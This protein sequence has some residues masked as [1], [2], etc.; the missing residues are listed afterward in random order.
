MGWHHLCTGMA[1]LRPA[2][3]ATFAL[4]EGFVVV[5]PRVVL[6]VQA[7]G[8]DHPETLDEFLLSHELAHLL[9]LWHSELRFTVDPLDRRL[10][11]ATDCV[12]AALQHSV[13]LFSAIDPGET[14]TEQALAQLAEFLGNESD[15]AR[16]RVARAD[17]RMLG[18][19]M[20]RS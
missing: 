16:H 3:P 17:E 20:G 8:G 12:A 4:A 18:V 13:R 19:A 5:D 15:Q 2:A 9:Q 7:L 10:E 14:L 11:I 1:G 6:A